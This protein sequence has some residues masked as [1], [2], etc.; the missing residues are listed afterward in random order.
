MADE[1]R[2]FRIRITGDATSIVD[3]SGKTVGVLTN[4]AGAQEEAGKQAEKHSGH[5]Q[6]LHKLFHSLNE[7]VPGLGVL[8]QAAFSPVGATISLAFMALRLFHEKMK[9]FNEECRKAA[10]EAA[11]PLT[12]RLEQQRETVVRTVDGMER[13]RERLSD[14]E[15]REDSLKASVDR[16]TAAFKAQQQAAETL[17]DAMKA[18]DIAGLEEQHAR[19]IVSEEQFAQQRLAIEQRYQEKK[20]ELAEQAEMREILIR[21]RALEQAELKQPGLTTSAE[22]AESKKE[23][24][25]E[26]LASLRPRAEIDDARKKSAAALKEFEEKQGL[27]RIEQFQSAGGATASRESLYEVLRQQQPWATS[28]GRFGGIANDLDRWQKL[29]QAKDAAEGAWMQAPGEEA[30]RKVAADRASHEADRAAQ[31]AEENQRF[32]TEGGQDVVER[33]ARY[34]QSHR[35]S[36]ELGGIERETLRKREDTAYLNS[37]TGQMVSQVA[38]TEQL[39]AHAQQITAAQQSQE[40]ALL[41]LL[42]ALGMNGATVLAALSHQTGQIVGLTRKIAELQARHRDTF[43]Q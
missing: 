3:A 17:N 39:R 42:Q 31:K 43:N 21:K 38:A 27:Q 22:T 36:Q 1:E 24:A 14:A 2:E 33:R 18:G 5:I 29:Q 13:L 11:K 12:N 28:A 16:T 15:R 40:K 35:D 19:G 8:M 7:I 30:R 25:P 26:D 37:P 23:K 41:Q 6:G 4:V 34:D 10:E 20:R 32:I 9:E